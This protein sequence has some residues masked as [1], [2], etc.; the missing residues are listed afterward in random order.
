MKDFWRRRRVFLTGHTGFKG[1]WLALWLQRLGAEVSGYSLEP[2]TNPN[3]FSLV[4]VNDGMRSVIGDINQLAALK[5]AMAEVQPEVVLHLAA[6]PLVHKGYDEPVVTYMTNVMGTAHV[7]ESV[8]GVQGIRAVVIVTTDKCYENSSDA[9]K[10]FREEDRLGGYDPYSN[11]KACAELVVAAYR[12]SY[13]NPAQYREHG[14]AVATARAGN[15]I[16]GGD[17]NCDRLVPDI[18]R[19]IEAS[20]PVMIRNPY[21]V[22]PWQHV[23]EP[24]QGY[25]LL[26]ERLYLEGASF[27]EAWNF[28]PSEEGA[29]SVEWIVEK[30]NRCWPQAP[31]WEPDGLVRPHEAQHLKLDCSKARSRLGWAPRLSLDDT[32]EWIAHWHREHARGADM[33]AVSEHQLE[34]FEK[35][36]QL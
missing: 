6:Q 23:L 5:R 32:I 26:A 9:T 14:V 28:G 2:S 16:G 25:L 17:W 10:G 1:G 31:G 27:A 15:V 35:L 36:A 21:A 22:R 24:L 3:L 13:F 11:S 7:L 8:R 19:A 34:A 29:K 4:R 12:S 20:K 18:L 33:R 30:L